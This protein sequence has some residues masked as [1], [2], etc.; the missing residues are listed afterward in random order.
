M[1][2]AVKRKSAI[3]Y[4]GSKA[5]LLDWLLP[6]EP[7]HREYLE[8][9]CG[10]SSFF[11]NKTPVAIETI[12]DMDGR[13]INFMIVLRDR[14]DELLPLLEMTLYSRSEFQLAAETS[15]DPVEDARRFFVK[16]LMSFGGITNNNRRTNSFRVD[17]RESRRGIAAC[18]SKWLTKIEGLAEVVERLKM[19]QIDNRSAFYTIPK[20]NL[21]TSFIYADPPYLHNTRTSTD[22]Y[23]HEFEPVDHFKLQK[24]LNE[25]KAKVMISHYD[26]PEY[27]EWYSGPKWLKIVGPKRKSNLGKAEVNQECVW[28][29]YY[30]ELNL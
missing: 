3:N 21:P 12:S 27:Q 18:V 9:F 26:C 19:A 6:L 25:T 17:V 16:A 2:V 23:K 10:G 15:P 13:L 30:K 14:F 1:N 24:L 22:D 20:F 29:N 4:F 7:Y 28:I 11:L 5:R 8:A